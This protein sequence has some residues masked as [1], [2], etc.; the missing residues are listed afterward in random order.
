MIKDAIAKRRERLEFFRRCR[1]PLKFQVDHSRHHEA[2][3]CCRCT[4]PLF[5]WRH[6]QAE[7][8]SVPV[9]LH[10][11]GTGGRKCADHAAFG[12]ATEIMGRELFNADPRRVS[13]YRGPDSV[14]CYSDIQL[15]SVFGDA[16]E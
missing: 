16:S 10:K 12:I 2:S 4:V 14:G 6:D 11:R 15:S 9:P 8:E 1:S 7:T 5:A 3:V 13:S